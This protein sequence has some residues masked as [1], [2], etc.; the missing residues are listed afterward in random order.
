MKT[1]IQLEKEMDAAN[2]KLAKLVN[3]IGIAA[4]RSPEYR[5]AMIKYKAYWAEYDKQHRE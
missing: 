2:Q 3:K 1:L 5:D 4:I